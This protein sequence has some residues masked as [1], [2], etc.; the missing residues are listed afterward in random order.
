MQPS[1]QPTSSPSSQPSMQPSSQPSSSP[2]SQPSK[3]PT[4]QPAK[5][6]K[7]KGE[8][9]FIATGVF[10]K[11]D[12][13]YLD[14]NTLNN[15][16]NQLDNNLD[17]V[18][19][20][21]G[22]GIKYPP[23]KAFRSFTE[24]VNYSLEK[25]YLR[26]ILSNEDVKTIALRLNNIKVD[27][28]SK[29]NNLPIKV[30]N[31]FNLSDNKKLFNIYKLGGFIVDGVF[32]LKNLYDEA[33]GEV[34]LKNFTI[35]KNMKVT[36]YEID[37]S[38]LA[39]DAIESYLMDKALKNINN[40]YSY[41]QHIGLDY[42]TQLSE[43]IRTVPSLRSQ[44]LLPNLFTTRKIKNS[45]SKQ[46]V[47]NQ[48]DLDPGM[49]SILHEQYLQLSDP[50]VMKV[51]DPALN[52]YISDVFKQLSTY[53]LLT[54]GFSKQGA[55]SLSEVVGQKDLLE[56][57]TF[58]NINE[59]VNGSLSKTLDSNGK[60]KYENFLNSFAYKFFKNRLGLSLNERNEWSFNRSY[61]N[62]NKDYLIEDY[63]VKPLVPENIEN[64]KYLSKFSDNYYIVNVNSVINDSKTSSDKKFKSSTLT[65]YANMFSD[66]TFIYDIDTM[67]NLGLKALTADNIKVVNSPEALMKLN[68]SGPI[69]LP[70][71]G[72]NPAFNEAI[73]NKFGIL[74]LGQ[75]DISKNATL[76]DIINSDSLLVTSDIVNL[77]RAKAI[78]VLDE[79]KNS[80]N[81]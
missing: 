55:F 67:K 18:R 22:V 4:T 15:I 46:L 69:A 74:N 13:I 20:V 65:E 76:T 47:L 70:S 50:G 68:I 57:G 19:D 10:I 37:E 62:T 14:I 72:L 29:L 2:S 52:Q 33:S 64:F 44:Y 40:V 63:Q 28:S 39:S 38:K 23:K 9:K 81:L 49:I 41:T 24:F 21:N 1:S 54:E 43:L 56:I 3:Q 31:E 32:G 7:G 59:Y 53:A 30:V 51:E 12:K 79:L 36:Q 61:L 73:A 45:R 35:Q 42:P 77:I 48:A 6:E 60:A 66:V 27:L 80:C 16:Y 34:V 8:P 71:N 26:N 25:E 58:N 5:Q 78:N 75:R 17:T 11:D